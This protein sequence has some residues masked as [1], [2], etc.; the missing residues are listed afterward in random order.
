MS[1][2]EKSVY[3][4]GSRA[5]HI[6][7]DPDLA[8]AIAE[9]VEQGETIKDISRDEG[10]PHEV[11]ICRWQDN[12]P[13]FANRVIRARARAVH[14]IA[15]ENLGIVRACRDSADAQRARAMTDLLRVVGPA[16][17]RADFGQQLS[18]QHDVRLS[19]G[20]AVESARER[21][22]R[23]TADAPPTM[24]EASADQAPSAPAQ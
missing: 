17:N 24:I 23:M 19:L 7:Y 1:A 6:P 2:V 15:E 10:M 8:E 14:A 12:H 5:P 11:T 4:G 20:A 18:V 9:R 22:Q 16:W 21:A 13:D 3:R